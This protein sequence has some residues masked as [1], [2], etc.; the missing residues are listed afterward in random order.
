MH[1]LEN[2][3]VDLRSLFFQD[4]SAPC[5]ERSLKEF[6]HFVHS[7]RA[8]TYLD[9]EHRT[10][11]NTTGSPLTPHEATN[12]DRKTRNDGI[13]RANERAAKYNIGAPSP[14]LPKIEKSNSPNARE[15]ATS[16]ATKKRKKGRDCRARNCRLGSRANRKSQVRQ[17]LGFS[18]ADS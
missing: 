10:T 14:P 8:A 1:S 15:M 13:P 11:S 18:S 9:Q 6:T 17:C 2:L 16:T 4:F 5:R 7:R 12:S 3:V